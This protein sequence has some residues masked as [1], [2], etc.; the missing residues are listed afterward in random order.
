VLINIRDR[1]SMAYSRS[2]VVLAWVLVAG[3]ALVLFAGAVGGR[4]PRAFGAGFVVLAFVV[5]ASAVLDIAPSL[6]VTAV[7]LGAAFPLT[8]ALFTTAVVRVS[9]RSVTAALAIATALAVAA[10]M[11]LRA[12]SLD[13]DCFAYCGDNPLLLS[14]RPGLVLTA[15]RLLAIVALVW[16]AIALSQIVNAHSYAPAARVGAVLAVAATAVAAA[17]GLLR[18]GAGGGMSDGEITPALVVIALVPAFALAAAPELLTWRTR[19]RVRT[20]ASEL[21]AGFESDGVAGHLQRAM[22]DPSVRLAF[23]VA[24]GG[25][26]DHRGETTE[27]ARHR[28]TTILARDGDPIAV[29]EHAPS[30]SSL[31]EAAVNPAVT[32][33]AENERLHAEAQAHLAELQLSRRRIV[34]RADETRR[35]L[36]RDLHDGAQ[37]QLLLLGLELA[38]TAEAAGDT[39]RDRYVTALHH[40]QSALTELRRLVHD[41]LPP[42]LDEFGLVEAL[43]TLAETSPVPLVLEVDAAPLTRPDLAVERVAYGVALSSLAEAEAHGASAM[44]IR[45]EKRVGR[46]TVSIRHDGVGAADHTDD[47]DRVGALGGRLDVLSVDD[48][49]AYVAS[50]P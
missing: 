8:I 39:D 33:A 15:D 27:I 4:P 42:V 50:F 17:G 10:R 24:A 48:G 29:V 30:S 3:A 22:A 31:I 36:E 18:P 13:R 28:A 25:Y 47:E 5:P 45:V 44:S 23:P 35:H 32:I 41:Q 21:P 12:P 20:L 19:L 1:W 6:R 49:V 16:C 38:R 37:Q 11:F 40:A 14:D 26:I 43:R 9:P 2:E 7:A 34:E 46:F